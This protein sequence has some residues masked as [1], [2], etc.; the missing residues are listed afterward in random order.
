ML[1]GS[2]R[3]GPSPGTV[4]T[5]PLTK[6]MRAAA[7]GEEVVE[8]EPDAGGRVGADVVDVDLRRERADDDDGTAA[9]PAARR[10]A[11]R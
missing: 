11:R 8:G 5:G 4:S 9:S 10:A 6:A 1:R 2:R 7:L 3:G